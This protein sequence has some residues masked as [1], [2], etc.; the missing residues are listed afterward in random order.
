M[1]HNIDKQ[2][3]VISFSLNLN[4]FSRKVYKYFSHTEVPKVY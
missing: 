4:N 3:N 2:N 1:K